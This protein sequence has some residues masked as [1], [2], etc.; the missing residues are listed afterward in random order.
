M[1]TSPAHVS[2][3]RATRRG[4]GLSVAIPAETLWSA[5]MAAQA[6]GYTSF[7]LNNPPGSGALRALSGVA[8]R[9]AMIRLGVGVIPLSDH[10][11]G[12]IV[13]EVMHSSVPPERL[14][15]GIGSGSG[16]G[17]V[18]RVAEGIGAIRS[19]LECS[20]VIAALGPKMCHLAGAE[21]DGVLLNWLTPQWAENSIKWVR[22]GA[23]RAGKRMP[24]VMAYVRVAM[25]PE[26]IV[27]LQREAA[28]YEAIPHYAAHFERMGTPAVGTAVTGET[29]EDIRHG[30]AAWDG[31]VDEVVVRVVV[32]HDSVE[33]V[34]RAVGA[35]RPVA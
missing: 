3:D 4:L 8:Q 16:A 30:L 5:A 13:R 24:R 17:A 26:A 29:S 7:W 22:D 33:E 12:E 14:Y 23:N 2:H 34:T 28:R 25:G 1:G 21:A 10:R 15:L 31:V 27:H 11:P 9:G 19:R 18:K 20:L 32:A 35:A 6:H